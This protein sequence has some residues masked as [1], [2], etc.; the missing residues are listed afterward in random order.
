MN[1]KEVISPKS[2]TGGKYSMKTTDFYSMVNNLKARPEDEGIIGS[3]V[4]KSLNFALSTI[5]QKGRNRN[6]KAT[7]VEHLKSGASS[8]SL[9]NKNLFLLKH[10]KDLKDKKV[11]QVIKPKLKQSRSIIK[12]T[13]SMLVNTSD[14]RLPSIHKNK[15]EFIQADKVDVSEKT[16]EKLRMQMVNWLIENKKD[17]ITK[18]S[19]NHA[20]I[21]GW[22]D[23][24]GYV[25]RNEFEEILEA[26]GIKFDLVLFQR[27]FWLFDVNG[28]GGVDQ[29]EAIAAL[30]LFRD[31]SFEE[32]LKMFFELA[33]DDDKGFLDEEKLIRLFK[34]NLRNEEERKRVRPAVRALLAKELNFADNHLITKN[35]LAKA[36]ENIPDLQIVVEK[37][38]KYL[39]S[40]PKPNVKFTNSNIL[41]SQI[42]LNSGAFCLPYMERLVD[43]IEQKEKI[44]FSINQ[45]KD[46]YTKS[47]KYMR[48]T[49]NGDPDHDEEFIQ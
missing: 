25:D 27:L 39:K 20:V 37:N 19:E 9:A 17:E 36:C 38:V 46:T 48:E 43:A 8:I 14:Q 10:R 12:G 18:I 6:V 16:K 24:F 44:N 4:L 33:D 5:S 32:K 34:R 21:I 11:S 47:L 41:A 28:D 42:N 31:H 15:S 35:D 40:G 45:I 30:E 23:Y 49:Q 29:R 22:I 13:M 2:Y 3:E 1:S 26:M 7:V